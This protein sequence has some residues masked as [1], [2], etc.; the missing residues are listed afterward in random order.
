MRNNKLQKGFVL[1]AI[2]AAAL[3]AASSAQAVDVGISGQINRA[4][5]YVDDGNRGKWFFVDNENSSTRFRFTGSNDFENSWKVG[6]VWEVEMQS[7]SSDEVSMDVSDIGDVKFKER[8]IE[9]WVGQEYGR[10]WVGQGDM[11]SNSTAEVDLSGTTVVAYS[12][13]ADVAG[14]FEF[15]DDG[16]GTGITVGGSRSNFDGLS[17]RDRVRY[18]TPKFAGFY[19]S[20]STAG[21]SRW[22][23]ALRYSGDF[24]W[25]KL[26]AAGAYADVGTTSDTQDAIIS[27]SASMLFDF[28]LNLTLAYGKSDQDGTD[29]YNLFGKVGYQF[30]EKHAVSVQWG[31]TENLSAKDDEGDS[32]GIAYVYSPWQ[33]VEFYGSYVLHTL[34]R[35]TGSDPDDITALFFGGRV[36]F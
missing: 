14:K 4:V 5:M 35:D 16:V 20:A 3:L 33:S 1:L 10:L 34:D 27:T 8:K 7:N 36:K 31:H 13:M 24:G 23:A 30:L 17:R 22:D 25:A 15:Q 11:A 21:D 18:D 29:P 9:F 19:G 6:I 28:G 26:A 12:S 32:Y 2:T